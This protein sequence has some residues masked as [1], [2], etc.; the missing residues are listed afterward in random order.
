[1]KTITLKELKNTTNPFWIETKV[2]GEK[3]LETKLSSFTGKKISVFGD[4]AVSFVV[5]KNNF[6]ICDINKL[7]ARVKQWNKETMMEEFTKITF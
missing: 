2:K 5:G 1:M 7:S 3:W 6:I 4:T